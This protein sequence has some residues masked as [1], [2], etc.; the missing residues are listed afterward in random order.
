MVDSGFVTIYAWLELLDRKSKAEADAPELD[1]SHY[2]PE[3]VPI[4]E[5]PQVNNLSDINNKE[6]KSHRCFLILA[7]KLHIQIHLH[8]LCQTRMT[9]KL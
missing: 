9:R 2:A 4:F 1:C 7:R 3:A 6:L 8:W 5:G